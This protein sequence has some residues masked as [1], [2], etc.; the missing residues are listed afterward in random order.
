MVYLVGRV[1]WRHPGR[2]YIQPFVRLSAF[3][4]HIS[5]THGKIFFQIAHTDHLGV[6]V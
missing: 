6:C 1:L 4:E 5:G 2:P 3:Q